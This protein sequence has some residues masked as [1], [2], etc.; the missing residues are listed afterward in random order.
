MLQRVLPTGFIAT[1]LRKPTAR[2]RARFG[3]MRSSTMASAS[4]LARAA[5]A[6][7]SIAAGNNLT[8]R[9]PL[10]VEGLHGLRSRSRIIDGEAVCCDDKGMPS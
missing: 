7:G 1:C 3:A 2:P 4:S 10:I 5:I 9:F 6:C 8:H